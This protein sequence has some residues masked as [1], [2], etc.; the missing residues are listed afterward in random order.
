MGLQMVQ[1]V[2]QMRRCFADDNLK[3]ITVNEY[4]V[5]NGWRKKIINAL[6]ENGMA[7]S[8]ICSRPNIERFPFELKIKNKMDAES[9]EQASTLAGPFFLPAR[10]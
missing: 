5:R 6:A 1:C 3:Q 7:E 10:S 2:G 8:Y 4:V 9:P